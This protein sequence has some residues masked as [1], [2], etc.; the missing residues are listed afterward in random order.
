MIRS[1][2]RGTAI[3]MAFVDKL[4]SWPAAFRT[5]GEPPPVSEPAAK[6][7]SDRPL[8]WQFNRSELATCA[9]TGLLHVLVV[10]V[11]QV[12]VHFPILTEEHAWYLQS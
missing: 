3:Q 10:H 4:R 6:S 12:K 8:S 7:W 2:A 1:S 5:L 9:P 11:L